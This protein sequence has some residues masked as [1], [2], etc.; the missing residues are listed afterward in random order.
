[1][2]LIDEIGEL[3]KD[4]DAQNW[5]ATCKLLKY[6]QEYSGKGLFRV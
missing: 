2:K 5:W 1:M 4:K 6:V 3:R